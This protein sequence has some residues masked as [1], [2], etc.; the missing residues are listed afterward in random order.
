MKTFSNITADIEKSKGL[1]DLQERKPLNIAQRRK[2]AI[3]MKRLSK[4]GAFKKKRELSL[5]RVASGDKLMKR[6]MKR[7]KMVM[8]KKFYGNIDYANLPISAKMKID[9]Q[10]Q[11][12]ASMIPKIAKKLVRIMRKQ[13]VERVRKLKAGGNK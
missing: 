4:S 1:H 3:R 6:A 13:E 11:K 2:L 8:I 10:L 7:A 9:M 12:K 5:R